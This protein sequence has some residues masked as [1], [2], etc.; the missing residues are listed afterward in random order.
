MNYLMILKLKYLLLQDNI[1]PLKQIQK[2]KFLQEQ[3]EQKIQKL[4]NDLE[5]VKAN[6][7][8][9]NE[10]KQHKL[11]LPKINNESIINELKQKIEKHNL[12]D[13]NH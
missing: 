11:D 4:T 10:K 1:S 7:E 13:K 8:K 2:K 12:F 5:T 9:K 3:N 6:Y